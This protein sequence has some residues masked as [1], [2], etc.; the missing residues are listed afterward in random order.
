M[1]IG[2][3]RLHAQGSADSAYEEGIDDGKLLHVACMRVV[4]LV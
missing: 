1:L 2:I 4:H 3:M